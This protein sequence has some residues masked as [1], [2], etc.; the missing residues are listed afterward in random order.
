MAA[1]S[2]RGGEARSCLKRVELGNSDQ[3]GE[4]PGWP[5]LSAGQ[6]ISKN[7]SW[8]SWGGSEWVFPVTLRS[9]VRGWVTH[10]G[11]GSP[12]EWLGLGWCGPKR[13]ARC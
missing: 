4:A 3:E 13:V 7:R 9:E 10:R 12:G 11:L 2:T 6:V 1:L 8:A 5:P